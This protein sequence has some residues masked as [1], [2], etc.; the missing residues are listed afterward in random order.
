VVMGK[1]E[2]PPAKP[3]REEDINTT[4]CYLLP[5]EIV[6]GTATTT[7]VACSP[8]QWHCYHHPSS[9]QPATRSLIPSV[10]RIIGFVSRL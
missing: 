2:S 4:G 5:E 7:P 8:P 3:H 10:G 9:M 1:R 6:S